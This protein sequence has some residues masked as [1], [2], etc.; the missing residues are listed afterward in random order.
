MAKADE[1]SAPEPTGLGTFGGVFTPSILTILGVIMYLRFGWVVGHL[2]L[3]KL[4]YFYD[5]NDIS[6]DGSTD[7]TFSEDVRSRFEAVGWQVLDVDGHVRR[8]RASLAC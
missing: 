1:R 8:P 2:G 5:D 4:V 7:I 6:I 3:G